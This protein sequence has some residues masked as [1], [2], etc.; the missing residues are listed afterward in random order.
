M[1]NNLPQLVSFINRAPGGL[2][3]ASR[4][5][6]LAVP[7][8]GTIK[9]ELLEFAGGRAL[10]TMVDRRAVR[11]HLHCIHALAL[12]NLGELTANLALASLCPKGGRFIVLRLETD[13]LKKAR[14][15]LWARCDVPADLPWASV[16]RTAATAYLSNSED[17]VV[18]R[19]TVYWKLDLADAQSLA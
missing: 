13:Y 17:E 11:N 16:T 19:V 7:Y 6:R 18:T 9:A 5:L 15:P 4:L 14:G 2:W 12:A 8:A 1:L 10:M 3:I